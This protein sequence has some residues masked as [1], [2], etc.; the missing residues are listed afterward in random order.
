VV[1]NSAGTRAYVLN[2][3]SRSISVVDISNPTA[4]AVETAAQSTALP[5][6]NTPGAAALLGQ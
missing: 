6:P 3:V 5:A 2:Y 1:I 4:P